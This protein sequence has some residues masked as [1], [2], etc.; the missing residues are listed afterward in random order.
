M[1]LRPP[2]VNPT[3][4]P[5]SDAAGWMDVCAAEALAEGGDGVRFDWP[6]SVRG[7]I[8]AFVVR[9]DGAPRA[10][11]NRCA[12]VPVELDW[13]PGKFLDESGLY[14]VC[15]THGAMYDAQ[16]GACVGGPCRGAALVPLVVREADGRVK[17]A[18]PAAGP[19]SPSSP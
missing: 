9:V 5:A 15:A 1:A 10:Y 19:A 16:S 12:H 6:G 3:H 11:L 8:A 17:V 4:D 18:L 14:L 2:V 7:P 13:L